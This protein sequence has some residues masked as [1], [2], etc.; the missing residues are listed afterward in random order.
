MGLQSTPSSPSTHRRRP[1]A[2]MASPRKSGPGHGPGTSSYRRS[3]HPVQTRDLKHRTREFSSANNCQGS[4]H[5]CPWVRFNN[6]YGRSS[7]EDAAPCEGAEKVTALSHLRDAG[8]SQSSPQTPV[9][10]ITVSVRGRR[11]RAPS[12][13]TRTVQARDLCHAHTH[14]E[15]QD[16]ADEQLARGVPTKRGIASSRTYFFSFQQPQER[17]TI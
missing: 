16:I 11:S 1:I 2:R 8:H 17:K 12:P 13:R 4:Q 15:T 6:Y 3:C 9:P 10:T 5:D 14:Q 7:D